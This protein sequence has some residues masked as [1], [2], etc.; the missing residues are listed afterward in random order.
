[1][2]VPF[3]VETLGR[4]GPNGFDYLKN[5]SK[6][7]KKG[8][9]A[10]TIRKYWFQKLSVTLHNAIGHTVQRQLDEHITR[11]LHND[12]EA[13]LEEELLQSLEHNQPRCAA[14]MRR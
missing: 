1:M 4:I 2:V 10:T 6:R 8:F 11:E 13:Q 5:L 7:Y 12:E 3:A 14:V 9:K